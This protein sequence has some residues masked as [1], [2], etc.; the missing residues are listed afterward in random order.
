MRKRAAKG[1]AAVTTKDIA[2]RTG[3]SKMTVSRVLNNHPYVSPET[4][5]K[6]M[7]AVR[8]LGFRPNT[9]AKRFFTG[10]TK[11]IGVV[12][13]LEYMFSSF[14][15]KELFQ[16]M[17]ECAEEWG[18]DILLHN[19][20]SRRK[21][22]LEKC[23][24]LVKGKLV[25]GLLVAA[26]MNYDTYPVKLAND[27]VPLVVTGETPQPQ[28][29]NCVAIPNRA[30]ARD[31]VR[32]LTALGHK[33]I[34][35][36]TFDDTHLESRERLAGYRDALKDAGIAFDEDLVVPAHYNRLEAFRA[37]VTLLKERPD[38]TAVMAI[39]ADMA[40]GAADAC[41]TL[42]VKIPDHLSLLAFDDCAEME[43]NDPPISAVRQFP[44]KV[45]YDACLLLLRMLSGEEKLRRNERKLID[46]EFMERR[47]IA[48]P[49]AGKLS[50][51][52]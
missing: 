32:R 12:I 47:S 33:R 37:V 26:P 50:V 46:T 8:D 17:L 9:L 51:M 36:V 28:K 49:R 2:E 13:P 20:R 30:A 5:K 6:V 25:E 52:P 15:F 23:L 31:A 42:G 16:G 3:L 18:Y 1:E 11:L 44:Y 35:V 45:G 27:D 24:D 40:L 41:R 48:A 38:V 4:K 21:P 14:Y 22:P 39:N 7:D 10:K 43:Q 19:S 34:A 29:V